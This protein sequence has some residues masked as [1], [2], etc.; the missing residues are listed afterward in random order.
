M[1][2]GYIT[3]S[4]KLDADMKELKDTIDT[5]TL[6]YAGESDMADSFSKYIG[7]ETL[8]KELVATFI[9]K[10]ICYSKTEFEVEYTFADELKRLMGLI[11]QRGA[12][13]A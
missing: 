5:Y 4:E 6:T 9:K 12:D 1:K 10:I 8:S 2:S 13:V 3:E 7:V 11:E